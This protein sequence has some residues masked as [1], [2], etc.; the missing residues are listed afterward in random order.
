MTNNFNKDVA[1]ITGTTSGLGKEISI[2]LAKKGYHVI[3]LGK[4]A[5][6]LNELY[7]NINSFGGSATI[8]QLDL[9]DF[10]GID[11]LGLEINKKFRKLDILIF[12]AAKLGTLT[13]LIHQSPTEFEDVMKINLLSNFRLI[14]SLDLSLKKSENPCLYFI[15]SNLTIKRKA[16][17]GAYSISKSGLEQLAH[18]WHLE[19]KKKKV[20]VFIFHPRPMNTKLRRAAMPGENYEK[21]QTA[22]YAALKFSKIIHDKNIKER[23]KIFDL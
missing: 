4:D 8:V 7:D 13:P 19:N 22:H 10:V 14:R 20:K 2:T 5:N 6:K 12:N 21:N 1:L 17:W 16:Y 11:R 15:S 9:R 3:I 23:F 18:T